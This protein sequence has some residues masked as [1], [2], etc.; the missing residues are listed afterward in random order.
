M[1]EHT[2]EWS[3]FGALADTHMEGWDIDDTT[4]SLDTEILFK[5]LTA[6][7]DKAW[8]YISWLG[9]EKRIGYDEAA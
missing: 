7:F 4:I 5:K 2:G 9:D 6:V 8:S 1:S 3:E